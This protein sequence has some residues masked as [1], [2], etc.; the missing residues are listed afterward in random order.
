MMNSSEN[1]SSKRNIYNTEKKSRTAP[2]MEGMDTSFKLTK[3]ESKTSLFGKGNIVKVYEELAEVKHQL[4]K[5]VNENKTLTQQISNL[6]SNLSARIQEI[7]M[8]QQKHKEFADKY[9]IDSENYA[10]LK[11]ELFVLSQ[12]SVKQQV[13]FKSTVGSFID[14][15][16]E[17]VYSKDLK[18][19][20]PL[21]N[22]IFENSTETINAYTNAMKRNSLLSEIQ[23]MLLKNVSYAKSVFPIDLEGE[24][25][26]IK[27]FK[28]QQP[29]NPLNMTFKLSDKSKPSSPKFQDGKHI[30]EDVTFDEGSLKELLDTN[31][32]TNELAFSRKTFLDLNDK[33]TDF[34]YDIIEV[35]DNENE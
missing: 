21:N 29:I 35:K 4:S 27:C 19:F 1:A 28:I 33:L 26:Q 2:I 15:I 10:A 30:S 7:Q 34:N 25:E 20:T 22:S 32:N 14:V 9:F 13:V 31:T 17:L 24:L 16:D 5:Q 11:K 18:P 23:A 3:Q 8:L 6:K 12:S